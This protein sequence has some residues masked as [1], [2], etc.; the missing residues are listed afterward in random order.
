MSQLETL[1]AAGVV[2]QDHNL[3]AEDVAVLSSLSQEELDALI[4]TGGSVAKHVRKGV[5]TFHV[6]V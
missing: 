6:S 4:E 1:I 5:P 2:P 3:S